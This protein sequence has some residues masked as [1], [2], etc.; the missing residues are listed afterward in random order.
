MKYILPYLLIAF[1][2][3]CQGFANHRVP[4]KIILSEETIYDKVKGG[5]AGQVLGCSYGGT[6]E[7]KFLGTIIQ[8]HIPIEWNKN[9]VKKW[10]ETFPGL[11]DDVYVDLTFVEVIE[12]CGLNA[13]VDSFAT[14]FRKTEYP[15]WH[16]NQM[17]RYNLNQ[18][19][20]PDKCGY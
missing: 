13:P 14:A 16:A 12:R 1:I 5:W 11:Y 3:I 17:A 20:A 9:V 6:T 8:D 10:Y 2:G 4:K 7:F 15:L 18:G 19:V